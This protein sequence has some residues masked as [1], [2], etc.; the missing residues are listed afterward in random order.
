MFLKNPIDPR[1]LK[2]YFYNNKQTVEKFFVH[3]TSVKLILA[4]HEFM[5]FFKRA[6][7]DVFN[8][9]AVASTCFKTHEK[10]R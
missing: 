4:R 5:M 7:Q 1:F 10:V 9:T 6:V 3:V 8:T 2:T